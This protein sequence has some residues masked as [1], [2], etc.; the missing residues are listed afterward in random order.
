MC[1][2]SRLSRGVRSGRSPGEGNGKSTPVFL[3]GESH[4]RRNLVGYSPRGLKKSDTSERLHFHFQGGEG[5]AQ[6]EYVHAVLSEVDSAP[7]SKILAY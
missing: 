1:V 2:C 3:P 6:L 4:G 7:F 5:R